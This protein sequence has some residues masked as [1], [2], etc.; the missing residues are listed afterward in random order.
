LRGLDARQRLAPGHREEAVKEIMSRRRFLAAATAAAGVPLI[1]RGAAGAGFEIGLV[2]D[3]QYA[4]VEP[5]G[6]RFYRHS[7]AKLGAAVDHFNE[8]RLAFCVHLGDLIDRDWKSFDAITQPLAGSRHSWHQLLGNHDF[9][10]LDEHKPAVPRRLG[11]RWR[12]GSFDHRGYRFVVLDTNDVSTYAHGA[13]TPETRAAE[14]ELARLV[15]AGAPQARPWNGGIGPAQLAWFDRACTEARQARLKVIV[16]AH[17]PVVPVEQ[18]AIW[19]A[20]DVLAVIDR[21]AHIVAWLNGHNHRGA[22]VERG[23]VPYVTMHGMVETAD[24]TAYATAQILPD[25]MI[26][27]GSG[28]EP[29]RELRFRA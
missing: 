17:H 23:G 22:F 5:R 1:A 7:I 10:V 15:E 21:H 3:A 4:D 18:H 6:T 16:F 19:N 2:A 8:R 25:R 28:R 14:T 9:E 24:T 13:D 11:M 20:H 26:I 12:H 29:S 27:S